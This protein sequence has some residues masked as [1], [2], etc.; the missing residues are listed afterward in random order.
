MSEDNII[1]FEDL[2]KDQATKEFKVRKPYEDFLN[3]AYD[4]LLSELATNDDI[5]I[6]LS[7]LDRLLVVREKIELFIREKIDQL[8]L[9]N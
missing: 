8:E 6:N 9:N 5:F 4:Y 3:D 2:K 7:I 1:Q